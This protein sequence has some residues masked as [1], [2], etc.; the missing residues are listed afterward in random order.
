MFFDQWRFGFTVKEGILKSLQFFDSFGSAVHKVYLLDGSDPRAFDRLVEAYEWRPADL[1]PA[2][3]RHPRLSGCPTLDS[4]TYV[5]SFWSN[6]D[7]Q[8]DLHGFGALLMRYGLSRSH[9]FRIAGD[10]R[11]RELPARM[12]ERSLKMA[13][14]R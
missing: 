12:F 7:S 14:E 5:E 2:I 8:C 1:P 13:A 3:E 11:A 9:A 6:W 10:K 4:A